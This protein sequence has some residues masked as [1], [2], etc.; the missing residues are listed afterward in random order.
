MV[1]CLYYENVWIYFMNFDYSQQKKNMKFD[2]DPFE[3]DICYNQWQILWEFS[4]VCLKYPTLPIQCCKPV[5]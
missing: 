2:F 4:K 3:Q 5:T 1:N